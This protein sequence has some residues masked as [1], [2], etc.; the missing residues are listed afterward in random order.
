MKRSMERRSEKMVDM[1]GSGLT[2]QVW[3]QEN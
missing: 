2:D 3:C 1:I